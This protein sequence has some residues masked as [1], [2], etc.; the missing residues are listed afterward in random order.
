MT[1]FLSCLY[2][3]FFFVYFRMRVRKLSALNIVNH[4]E[5]DSD[6]EEH[7]D[8]INILPPDNTGEVT[9]TDEFDE[10]NPNKIP[11]DV[12]GTLEVVTRKD[13][14]SDDEPEFEMEQNPPHDEEL[15]Q[16]TE[17][18]NLPMPESTSPK[19][20]KA[21]NHTSPKTQKKKPKTAKNSKKSG[22]K[23]KWVK[24]CES[25]AKKVGSED[26]KFPKMIETMVAELASLSPYQ[27]FSKF[28]TKDIVQML[29]FES[30]RYAQQHNNHTFRVTH[31]EM[32]KFI[33]IHLFSGYHILPRQRLYWEKAEDVNVSLVS[34]SM[35]RHRFEEIK[36]YLHMAN[37][38]GLNMDDK[39][40][41]VRPLI[42]LVN[43]NLKQFGFFTR[44]LSADE[45]MLP[46]YGRHSGKQFMK[47]KPVKFG[48]KLWVLASSDGYPYH[49][50]PY[51]GKF[52][53]RFKINILFVSN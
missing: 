35:S 44:N 41:K 16:E 51:G 40:A 7:L 15:P 48:Y 37:N 10:D 45:Q 32:L 38:N 14:D 17:S 1:Q 4:L 3:A 46:Y 50:I 23:I 26:D 11:R 12:P 24:N 13:F 6:E 21:T 28:L 30:Q 52:N 20:R 31:D 53:L 36:K 49:L 22:E 5:L 43:Q 19:K 29:C 47:N 18:D 39:F 2:K 33:G 27:L 8:E 9:D 25:F 42:N 34:G